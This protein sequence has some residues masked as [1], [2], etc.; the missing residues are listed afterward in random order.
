MVSLAVAFHDKSDKKAGVAYLVEWVL[1][2]AGGFFAEESM[3]SAWIGLAFEVMIVVCYGYTSFK[4][5]DVQSFFQY[6]ALVSVA[7]LTC[8][9]WKSPK[10]TKTIQAE[11]LDL[12]W[13]ERPTID[14]YEKA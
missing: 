12:Q 4:P 9:G 5:W 10:K 3:Y 2:T 6:Y 13:E 14:A 8:S 1:Q 7:I 11:E